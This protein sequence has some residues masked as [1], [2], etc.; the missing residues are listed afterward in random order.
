VHTAS[1]SIH[2]LWQRVRHSVGTV[3]ADVSQ[4]LCR[5]CG[6][7]APPDSY[8][9]DGTPR[10]PALLIHS[11]STRARIAEPQRGG[12]PPRFSFAG[13]TPWQSQGNGNATP[14]PARAVVSL[15]RYPIGGRV[16]PHS[17]KARTQDRAV[18]LG[19]MLQLGQIAFRT[20]TSPAADSR[21]EAVPPSHAYCAARPFT[22]PR[23]SR[24]SLRKAI[25]MVCSVQD[26]RSD[27]KPTKLSPHRADHSAP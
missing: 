23:R 26:F 14:A 16:P 13:G 19:L 18:R 1:S 3:M 27:P 4:S 22:R 10:P 7:G 20:K 11:L 5:H 25:E 2:A 12:Y 24:P 6:D 15:I 21:L 8:E 17:M 9:G